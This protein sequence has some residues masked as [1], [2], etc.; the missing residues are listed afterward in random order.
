LE[1]LVE[2]CEANPHSFAYDDVWLVYN[3]KRVKEWRMQDYDFERLLYKNHIHAGI[4]FPKVAWE[5]VGGYPGIMDN[6]REDWAFNV[7]LGIQGWCGVHVESFGYLY[8]RENQNRSLTNTTEYHRDIFLSKLKSLFPKVY[9][10][11]RPMAC[12]GK[13][14]GA[15]GKATTTATLASRTARTASRKSQTTTQATGGQ[16]LMAS[17]TGSAGM[18]KIEYLGK[19]MSSIWD[20][21]VTQQRYR[22]GS[23]RKIGWVDNRDV[24][25]FLSLQDRNSNPLFRVVDTGAVAVEATPTPAPAVEAEVAVAETPVVVEEVVAV[26]PAA[27]TLT[28]P[29]PSNLYPS[30]IKRLNLTKEQWQG[31]YEAELAGKKRPTVITYVEE[32]LVLE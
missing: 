32:Q 2:A 7:A 24:N 4:V 21:P 12:C 15:K 8:R 28:F 31:L 1:L 25:G 20:G 27:S 13:G 26:A 3:H 5:Q 16:T 19:Q 14:G 11:D 23:D 6:G 17:S 29:D 18:T 22:F 30:D 10:G 9:E